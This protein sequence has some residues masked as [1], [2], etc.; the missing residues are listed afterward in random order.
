[1]LF[2]NPNNIE[3]IDNRTPQEIVDEIEQLDN[4]SIVLLKKI[5]EL[6]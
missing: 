4:Q 2:N 6:L 1:M 3:E 5:K